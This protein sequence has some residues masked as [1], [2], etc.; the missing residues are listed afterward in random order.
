MK[1]KF[2][3]N[4]AIFKEYGDVFKTNKNKSYIYYTFIHWVFIF[5]LLG[6]IEFLQRKH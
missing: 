4:I 6:Q 3:N 5:Q 2:I 1:V